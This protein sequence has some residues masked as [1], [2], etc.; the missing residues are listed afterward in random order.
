MSEALPWTGYDMAT[1]PSNHTR[2]DVPTR[3]R[4]APIRSTRGPLTDQIRVLVSMATEAFAPAPGSFGRSSMMIVRAPSVRLVIT[5]VMSARR[6]G[7]PASTEHAAATTTES[8]MSTCIR[9]S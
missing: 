2:T 1:G 9:S 4:P 8:A 6:V 5:P 7:G 3:S